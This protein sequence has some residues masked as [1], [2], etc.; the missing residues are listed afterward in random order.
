MKKILCYIDMMYRGG[1]QRVMANLTEYFVEQGYETVLVNDFVQDDDKMQ[2]QLPSCVKRIY[3][4]EKLEGNKILKNMVRIK[5]LRYVIK[6]ERPDV[7]LSFLGRPNKRML[8]ATL[9]LN[10][11]KVVSVRNDPNKEYGASLLEKWVIGQLFKLA[12]G[13]VFQTED[14]ENYFPMAVKKKSKIILNPVAESFFNTERKENPKNIVAFGRLEPQKNHILLI[15]AFED[16]ANE[17]PNENL[18]IYGDGTMREELERHIKRIGLQDRILLPGNTSNVSEEL[19]KAKIFALSSDY[20]GM[21]N[22]LMEALAVGVPSIS[23]DC[24]CGGPQMLVSNKI[25]GLLV[26]CGDRE[27]MSEAIKLLL[28]DTALAQNISNQSK[29]MAKKFKAVEIY[30]QWERYLFDI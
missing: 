11:K 6:Q 13:C 1:A 23:T 28:S 2:Y 14:A 30:E 21:P 19:S 29:S 15:N 10:T 26:P 24:P 7:V 25:N 18:I 22:A 20:E 5:K 9:G 8:L 3:L 27:A 12:D 4:R 17:F 16:I